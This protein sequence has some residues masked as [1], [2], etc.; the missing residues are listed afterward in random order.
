MRRNRPCC[1]TASVKLKELA[2]SQLK[3]KALV[4]KLYKDVRREYFL[5]DYRIEGERIFVG[6]VECI[7][8]DASNDGYGLIN[9]A[10]RF[11]DVP[12]REYVRQTV[13]ED[14]LEWANHWELYSLILALH[15][16]ELMIQNN[17]I[18]GFKKRIVWM[19]DNI[20]AVSDVRRH[21]PISIG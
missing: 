17:P 8:T 1:V 13:M 4:R 18:H 12:R 19:N 2:L 15:R 7:L 9:L 20:T 5:H 6:D 11:G 21:Y 14:G 3:G 10:E 16:R